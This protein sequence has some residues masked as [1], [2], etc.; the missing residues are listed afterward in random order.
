MVPYAESVLCN[1]LWMWDSND[2]IGISI[3]VSNYFFQIK[4]W[5]AVFQN[6][7]NHENEPTNIIRE[8]KVQIYIFRG[9]LI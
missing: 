7:T 9:F 3:V 4:N 2:T 1:Y 8:T 6:V 5:F